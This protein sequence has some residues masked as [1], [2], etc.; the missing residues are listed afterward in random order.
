MLK[1]ALLLP[2]FLLLTSPALVAQPATNETV[3]V[4]INSRPEFAEI[5][6]DGKFIGTT[7]LNY[8]L[9]PGV[10]RLELTRSRY[11][12]WVRELFVSDVPTGVTAILDESEQKPCSNASAR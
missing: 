10:H 8:R 5:H 12:P 1:K 3:H 7:P 2:A 6:V 11:S 4:S 9:T